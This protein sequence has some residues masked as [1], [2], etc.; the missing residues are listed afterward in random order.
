MQLVFPKDLRHILLS[1]KRSPDGITLG[2]TANNVNLGKVDVITTSCL[3][4][5]LFKCFRHSPLNSVVF[6]SYKSDTRLVFT[7]NY[8]MVFHCEWVL[9]PAPFM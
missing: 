9:Y 2:L 6:S 7:L 4:I 3:H 5:H 1:S 8:F